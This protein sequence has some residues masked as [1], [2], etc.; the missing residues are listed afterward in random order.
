MPPQTKKMPRKPG[1][2]PTKVMKVPVPEPQGLPPWKKDDSHVLLGC[3]TSLQRCMN[4][5]FFLIGLMPV[6][7]IG[8][9]VFILPHVKSCFVCLVCVMP[10]GGGRVPLAGG[11]GTGTE[12]WGQPAQGTCGGGQAGGN[13]HRADGS[14]QAT[15]SDPG[16]L[17]VWKK[18]FSVAL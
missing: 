2:P 5:S 7:L 10:A 3:F 16:G 13:P 12:T 6:C 1:G 18:R 9:I 15:C 8:L 4:S 17:V 11:K 14:P